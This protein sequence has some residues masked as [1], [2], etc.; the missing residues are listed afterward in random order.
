MITA[1]T[2]TI[3]PSTSTYRSRSNSTRSRKHPG[4]VQIHALLR[5][6]TESV[7]IIKHGHH[8]HDRH[9]HR[10]R[11]GASFS[12]SA[13]TVSP[14]PVD[15]PT[16]A[17]TPTS[18]SVFASALEKKKQKKD[19]G[20]KNIS[21]TVSDGADNYSPTMISTTGS[22]SSTAA[23][24]GSALASKT[25][26][27]TRQRSH[28]YASAPLSTLI[29]H[30]DSP[31][32]ASF[33]PTDVH[34]CA[35]G[36]LRRC[37]WMLKMDAYGTWYDG[38]CE[39][40]EDEPANYIQQSFDVPN[41]D[42]GHIITS[43]PL[44]QEKEPKLALPFR[45]WKKFTSQSRGTTTVSNRQSDS[46]S[47]FNAD[48]D[49]DRESDSDE[50]MPSLGSPRSSRQSSRSRSSASQSTSIS[51]S[52]PNLFP[53]PSITRRHSGL[54][55]NALEDS[56]TSSSEF[57]V[58]AGTASGAVH[59]APSAAAVRG[60]HSEQMALSTRSG[61]SSASRTKS[62]HDPEA[63]L[64]GYKY[65]P[66]ETTAEKP[67]LSVKTSASAS[68]MQTELIPTTTTLAPPKR[69]LRSSKK[70]PSITATPSALP[71]VADLRIPFPVHSATTDT[72]LLQNTFYNNPSYPSRSTSPLTS[73][74][75][76]TKRLLTLSDL[77]R[78]SKLMRSTTT[79]AVCGRSGSDFS[80]CPRTGVAWCSRACRI[81]AK[82]NASSVTN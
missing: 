41:K 53:I 35:A 37:Q 4:P 73:T 8:D 67:Q 61:S 40:E 66:T 42:F 13:T 65:A 39:L 33:T 75:Q 19:D 28:S 50:H 25:G 49:I 26:T 36:S 20:V 17:T 81:A 30:L 32:L 14:T 51:P 68:A 70:R 57:G 11:R 77:E 22:P 62:G 21:T 80:R 78:T 6:S 56:P 82:N 23:A 47:G 2:T 45:L 58:W 5:A 44:P 3:T 27:Q 46:E 7:N 71:D 29:T 16:A 72:T 60:G 76:D 54:G 38:E 15:R 69:T 9:R 1:T 12:A 18:H 34:P 43:P 59:T 55:E 63:S 79:C 24:P 64:R 74:S 10:H 48:S 31:S 52:S